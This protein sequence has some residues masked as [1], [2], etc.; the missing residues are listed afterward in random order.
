MLTYNHAL[1]YFFT[2]LFTLIIGVAFWA[3]HLYINKV[4]SEYISLFCLMNFIMLVFGGFSFGLLSSGFRD[5][6]IASLGGAI[7]VFF[8]TITFVRLLPEYAIYFWE[9]IVL[10]AP[11]MYGIGK[12]GCS[13]AH[14]CYGINYTG[15]FAVSVNDISY[16]PIQKLESIV[17]LSLFIGSYILYKLNKFN[18]DIAVIVYA[19]V[20]FLLD[21]LRYTH[22]THIISLNQVG[23]LAI[24]AVMV[25]FLISPK[26]KAAVN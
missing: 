21:F 14:C 1:D 17:F 13:L 24:I 25:Y 2:I 23:C 7:G 12:I 26:L 10:S 3:I 16:F 9:S 11:L 19:A 15:L 18:C 20:K 8:C 4:K 6:A 5:Y 22:E